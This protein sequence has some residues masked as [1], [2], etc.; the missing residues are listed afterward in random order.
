LSLNCPEL[1]FSKVKYRIIGNTTPS[2]N[3]REEI[4]NKYKTK[5]VR[6]FNKTRTVRG[7]ITENAEIDNEESFIKNIDHS[8]KLAIY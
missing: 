4:F 1:N 8:R 3:Q 5:Y 2:I 6:K 7:E